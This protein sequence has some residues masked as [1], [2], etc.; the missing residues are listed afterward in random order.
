[1]VVI[2]LLLHICRLSEQTYCLITFPSTV[3]AWRF[4][5]FERTAS[6]REPVD[7]TEMP[8]VCE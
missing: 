5:I 2:S 1:M 6:A 8:G 4:G 7:D 3:A